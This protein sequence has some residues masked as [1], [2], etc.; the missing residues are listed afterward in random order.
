METVLRSRK[1]SAG[2]SACTWGQKAERVGREE[3]GGVS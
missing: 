3:E 2:C 1:L